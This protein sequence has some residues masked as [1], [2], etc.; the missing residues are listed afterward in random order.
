[1]RILCVDDNETSLYVLEYLI[2]SNGYEV[3]T[4]VNGVEGLLKLEAFS[5][6]LIISDILMP[7]MDGFQFCHE[8][9]K[10]ERFRQIPF[11]FY[12]ANYTDEKDRKL[13]LR[14]GA[15]QF[16]IKPVE[17]EMLLAI[18]EKELCSRRPEKVHDPEEIL[19]EEVFLNTY[20]ERLVKKIEEHIERL[21][22]TSAE[23]RT[24]LEDKNHQIAERERAEQELHRLAMRLESIREEERASMAREI[25][26]QLGQNLT[27]VKFELAALRKEIPKDCTSCHER[28][29]ELNTL[30]DGTIFTVKRISS[31]LRPRILDDLGL[32]SA[33]RWQSAEFEKVTGIKSTCHFIPEDFTVRDP[34]STAAFRICQEALTNVARHSMA[35]LVVIKARKCD[36]R[37]EMTIQDNGVGISATAMK[38]PLS[39]GIQGIRERVHIL[40]G[41]VRIEGAAGM[42]TTVQIEIPLVLKGDYHDENSDNR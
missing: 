36:D 34:L 40:G 15:S 16:L 27:A 8:V 33:I 17:P 26:D 18:I 30:I 21:E 6:D 39:L 23:L 13:A 5:C 32:I 11:L 29:A 20:N 4:A 22:T 37:L 24:T 31:A 14:L 35:S 9:K 25:H 38:N 2:H 19:H 41:E 7:Q 10:Q 3:V 1:M 12:T 42:G 28:L